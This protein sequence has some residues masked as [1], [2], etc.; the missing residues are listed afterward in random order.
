MAT[1]GGFAVEGG[2]TYAEQGSYAPIVTINDGGGSTTTVTD[3]ATIADAALTATAVSI[4][5]TKAW[6][7]LP[8]PPRWRRLRT[9]TRTARSAATRRR[10]IGVQ[11]HTSSG[12]IVTTANG[13]AVE[14]GHTY[15]EQGSYTPIVTINDGGGSTTTVT[16]SATIADAALT[17]TAVSISGT[18][19]AALAG[20][21]TVATFTDADPN[22]TLGDYTATINLGDGHTFERD[23]CDD[24]Q[25]LCGRGRPHLCGARQLYADRDHQRRWRQHDD[26]D[27]QRDDC[28]CGADGERR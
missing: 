25:R 16:Y 20:T 1:A 5:G 15:A 12:I 11:R 8:A 13:F 3:S 26:G 7:R 2:H 6:G 18:E 28:G 22:G 24:R 9:P 17:A 4:S 14:A 23:H 19:G 10:S 21:T 27:R